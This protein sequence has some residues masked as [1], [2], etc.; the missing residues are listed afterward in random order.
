[1]IKSASGLSLR[2]KVI[3]PRVE[4]Q[5]I[6]FQV[7]GFRCQQISGAKAANSR[8]RVSKPALVGA[9]LRKKKASPRQAETDPTIPHD[10]ILLT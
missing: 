9:R 1:M 5:N 3:S 6:R 4:L 7:S 8:R 2:V 10:L